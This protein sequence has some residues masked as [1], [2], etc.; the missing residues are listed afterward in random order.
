MAD[1]QDFSGDRRAVALF[2]RDVWQ[3]WLRAHRRRPTGEELIVASYASAMSLVNAEVGN[4]FKYLGAPAHIRSALQEVS[5][6]AVRFSRKLT[7]TATNALV[8]LDLAGDS[9]TVRSAESAAKD[10]R[11]LAIAAAA[12]HRS[13]SISHSEIGRKIGLS[14]TSTRDRTRRPRRPDDGAVTRR[15]ALDME[16]EGPSDRRHDG[17][18]RQGLARL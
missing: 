6:G 14:H 9:P 13:G 8:Y 15:C 1:N 18:D 12:Y 17:S 7:D 4:S 5:S 16:S 2:I 11:I 3:H 10:R